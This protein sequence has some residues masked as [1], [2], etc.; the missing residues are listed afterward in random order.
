MLIL[1]SPAVT[2]LPQSAMSIQAGGKDKTGTE[3]SVLL[4]MS[5]NLDNYRQ[6]QYF[7]F[8]FYL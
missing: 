1:G 2:S 7:E 5:C 6:L 4:F 8:S 3:Y